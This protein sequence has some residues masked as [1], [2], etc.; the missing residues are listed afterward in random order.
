MLR[1]H[2]GAEH[3]HLLIEFE[4]YG[5][6][7]VLQVTCPEALAKV[8]Q[9]W[10]LPG[11]ASR[12]VEREDF[13]SEGLPFFD[14][15]GPAAIGNF[16]LFYDDVL[17]AVG[18]ADSGMEAWFHNLMA[19][20]SPQIFVHAGVVEWH[21]KLLLFPAH[22]FSGKSTLVQALCASGCQYWSD[23]F[24]VMHPVSGRISA[25][26]RRLSLRPDIRVEVA[27]LGGLPGSSPL[28]PSFLFDLEYQEECASL[29]LQDLSRGAACLRLFTNTVAAK[30]FGASALEAFP[31]AL[32]EC[33]CFRGVRGEAKEAAREI[34]ALVVSST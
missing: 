26:P 23:E 15:V 2:R 22:T 24:A 25:F 4:A 9:N 14:L 32:A 10:F 20:H 27:E 33:R 17:K 21:G 7:S 1:L 18:R 3:L 34:L 28:L 19:E 31:R 30:R 8:R 16:E 11:W 12:I 29:E 6:R 13:Q 5:F